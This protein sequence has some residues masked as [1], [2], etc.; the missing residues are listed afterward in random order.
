MAA[1]L[2]RHLGPAA[3]AAGAAR[4]QR[5]R[6]VGRRA[7]AAGARRVGGLCQRRRHAGG[8]R[9]RRG[10]GGAGRRRRPHGG[11]GARGQQRAGG[12][13]AWPATP[14]ATASAS[15][16]SC[17][18]R[19]ASGARRWP[20]VLADAGTQVLF[21]APHRI[22]ALVAELA[23]GAPQRRADAGARADQAVRDHRHRARRRVAGLAGRPTTTA[24]AANSCSCC[25]PCPPR[26]RRPTA[27]GPAALQ[28]LRVLL[29]ELPLKQAVALAAEITGAP[30][31]ALYQRA[32]A[33]RGGAGAGSAGRPDGRTHAPAPPARAGCA[34]ARPTGHPPCA[35]CCGRPPAARCSSCS[36]PPCAGWRCS[37]TRCRRNSCATCSACW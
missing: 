7:G 21:E 5:A 8:V 36:T 11:A 16:V 25:M 9:P 13:V 23:A 14:S 34:A 32:L 29:R 30:R 17:P 35:G 37:S 31:N 27:L 12:A 33:E 24:S 28:T 19:A 18:P 26:R 10:A 15:S 4:P 1:Q 2:L 3:A 20:R 6:G 22:S